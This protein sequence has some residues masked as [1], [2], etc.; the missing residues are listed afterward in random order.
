MSPKCTYLFGQTHRENSIVKRV[1]A[2]IILGR[3]TF[4]EVIVGT[5]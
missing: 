4:Q 1:Y 2:G 3:V 5:V